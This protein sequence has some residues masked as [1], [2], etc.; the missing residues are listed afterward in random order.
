MYNV[1]EFLQ[2]AQCE[3][4][5]Y[6]IFT[7]NIFK[8]QFSIA[9][10]SYDPYNPFNTLILPFCYVWH[11]FILFLLN[12]NASTSI[13]TLTSLYLILFYITGKMRITLVYTF[14][15]KPVLYEGVANGLHTYILLSTV[16]SRQNCCNSYSN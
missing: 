6:T 7:W 15:K 9:R 1:Y 4:Y 14:K 13:L 12:T 3:K 5:T 2:K 11:L 8:G 10:T 16:D